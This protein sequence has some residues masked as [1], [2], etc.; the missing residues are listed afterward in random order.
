M[1]DSAKNTHTSEWIGLHNIIGRQADGLV[2]RTQKFNIARHD[3]YGFQLALN[4]I[5]SALELVNLLD[6]S[7]KSLGRSTIVSHFL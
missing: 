6:N 7:L 5:A 4:D 3:K 1:A 2:D